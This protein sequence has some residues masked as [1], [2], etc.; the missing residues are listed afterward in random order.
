MAT[1][2][3]LF[4]MNVD[5]T[6]ARWRSDGRAQSGSLADLAACGAD[7]HV[8]LVDGRHVQLTEAELP[9]GNQRVQRQALPYALEE[10]VLGAV[11]T[12]GFA[13]HRLSET[14]LAA[15]VFDVAALDAQL[16][17]LAAA[18]LPVDQCVPDIL[19][20]PWRESTWTLL[21]DGDDAWLRTGSH[22]GARFARAQWRPFVAQAL[23]G[24]DGERHLRVYGASEALLAEIAALSPALVID[25]ASRPGPVEV[26]AL[27]AEGHAQGHVIDLLGAL[28]SRRRAGEGSTRRWWRAS[29]AAVVAAAIGHAGFMQ[30]HV[31]ALDMQVTAA[32]QTTEAV[33]RDMF[34]HITRIEDVRAQ[35]G[36]ALADAAAAATA[37]GPSFVDLFAAAGQALSAHATGDMSFESASYGNGTLELRVR[38][39]DMAMLEGY[40]QALGSADLPVQLLSVENRG[41][42]TVGLL[43]VGSSP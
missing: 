13:A 39:K 41:T 29:A 8:W 37:R 35:A 32:R 3:V 12:L 2:A 25:P 33:F 34:P 19:C 27:F 5:G 4:M 16:A 26:T 23:V 14:C 17:A 43:R 7:A 1:R 31:S 21:V 30:W 18:G 36:Q 24:V 9:P 11:D 6:R 28:P 20:V 15:A 40:Q 22:T 38:A 10:Q 42:E